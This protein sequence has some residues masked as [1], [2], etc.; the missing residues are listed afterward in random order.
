MDFVS[1]GT[2][3]NFLQIN[4]D[5][6]SADRDLQHLLTIAAYHIAHAMDH[7]RNKMVSDARCVHT[8]FLRKNDSVFANGVVIFSLVFLL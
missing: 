2:L 5:R 7:L 6:L 4:Q 1:N 8:K 3:R